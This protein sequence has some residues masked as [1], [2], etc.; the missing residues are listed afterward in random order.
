MLQHTCPF[1]NMRAV[2]IQFKRND[3]AN[4][5]QKMKR[6]TWHTFKSTSLT[7]AM[8]MVFGVA[9]NT[10]SVSNSQAQQSLGCFKDQPQRDLD[11]LLV[12]ID[13]LTT[14]QCVAICRSHGFRYAGT[15]YGSSCLCGNSYGRSGAANNCNMPCSGNTAEMCGGSYANSIYVVSEL[16]ADLAYQ[17]FEGT[18]ITTRG[19]LT[20]VAVPGPNGIRVNGSLQLRPGRRGTVTDG[21]YDPATRQLTYTYLQHWT[22]QKV[23]VTLTVSPDSQT[24]AG[25]WQ[26]PNVGQGQFAAKLLFRGTPPKASE[27]RTHGMPISNKPRLEVLPVLFIPRDAPGDANWITQRDIDIYSGLIF[28]HLELAQKRYKSLLKIDTFKISGEPLFVVRS[29]YDDAYYLERIHP[30]TAGPD[31]VTLITGEILRARHQDRYS[32]NNIFVT[33]YVR[34]KPRVGDTP[35]FGGGRPFNGAP[36]TGGGSLEL[37]LSSLLYDDLYNFQAALVHEIGHTFGMMHPDVYG[38]D[39]K[40]N[41]SIMA[42]GPGGGKFNPEEFFTLGQNKRAFPD[43]RYVA[44]EHNPNGRKFKPV[45]Y[46][47]MPDEI[48]QRRGYQGKI[49]TQW[50][51][52]C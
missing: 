18:W 28:A 21:Q 23:T 22:G 4:A 30:K 32:S 45:Y 39:Q 48:G 37:E 49:C 42:Y 2:S 8:L 25:T 40:T 46:Q 9:I 51:C 3:F 13:N 24:M 20:L 5:K 34:T 6:S 33:I 15:Q 43:F 41:E 7:L 38:Y 10:L 44:A 29:K 12:K 11:G 14:V 50:P 17:P 52:P 26:Q 31:A 1:A 36:N 35:A 19:P 47:C 16:A 27:A